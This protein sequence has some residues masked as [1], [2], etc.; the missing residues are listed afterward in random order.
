MSYGQK[1]RENGINR[2][3]PARDIPVRPDGRRLDVQDC[4]QWWKKLCTV[5]FIHD[6]N[7][8]INGAKNVIPTYG[9]QSWDS[10]IIQ[11]MG[12]KNLAAMPEACSKMFH[13]VGLAVL[14]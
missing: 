10:G 6:G 2:D 9:Q 11:K 7:L 4:S 13:G 14:L 3:N 5:I 12:A 8:D 1:L